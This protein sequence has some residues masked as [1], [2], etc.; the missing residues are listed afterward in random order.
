MCVSKKNG[1][2][3]LWRHSAADILHQPLSPAEAAC[4]DFTVRSTEQLIG[5][6]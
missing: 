6:A 4:T 2:L 3:S 1:T 5:P